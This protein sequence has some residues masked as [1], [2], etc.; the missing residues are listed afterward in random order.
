MQHDLQPT[1][2]ASPTRGDFEIRSTSRRPDILCLVTEIATP[3]PLPDDAP[4][5]LR[6]F[7]ACDVDRV[8]LDMTDRAWLPTPPHVPDSLIPNVTIEDDWTPSRAS[9]AVH[10]GPLTIH[11]DVKIVENGKLR[12]HL[13]RLPFGIGHGISD[14][15]HDWVDALNTTL[16]ANGKAIDELDVTDN[17]VVITKR[18]A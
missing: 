7:V 14:A 1:R 17:T 11:I 10:F 4:P 18:D 15:M 16:E 5:A 3:P 13:G 8:E 2:R 12:L 6:R 9:L